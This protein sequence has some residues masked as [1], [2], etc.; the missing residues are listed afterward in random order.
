MLASVPK[1]IIVK[2]YLIT[3]NIKN[4]IRNTFIIN[5]H[6]NL[7]SLQNQDNVIHIYWPPC[8]AFT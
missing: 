1:L 6:A 2:D 4:R 7:K 3:L 8:Y 5:L